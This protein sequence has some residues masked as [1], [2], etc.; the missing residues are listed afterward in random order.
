MTG[1]ALVTLESGLASLAGLYLLH[2]FFRSHLVEGRALGMW[3]TLAFAL[4]TL[5]LIALPVLIWSGLISAAPAAAPHRVSPASVLLLA[6][7]LDAAFL[8]LI[9]N[10]HSYCFPAREPCAN[11]WEEH[12]GA[13]YSPELKKR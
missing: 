13:P 5:V 1:S 8:W 10:I 3:K 11:P 4:A 2:R 6:G 12:W 7:Y 9:W